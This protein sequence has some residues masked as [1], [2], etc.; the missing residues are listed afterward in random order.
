MG[1][2]RVFVGTKMIVDG[3]KRL[4]CPIWVTMY[5]MRTTPKLRRN[6]KIAGLTLSL[7]LAALWIGSEWFQVECL[8]GPDVTIY[9]VTKG[10]FCIFHT[11][12]DLGPPYYN[13]TGLSFDKRDDMFIIP[14]FIWK[15]HFNSSPTTSV[16]MIPLWSPLFIVVACTGLIWWRDRVMT[17]WEISGCCKKCGYDRRGLDATTKCPECGELGTA[18]G[19]KA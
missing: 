9:R 6:M 12:M 19:T 3:Q 4:A 11:T 17:R 10:V 8:R 18:Q 16:L 2:K 5:P 1:T 7:L 15:F 14:S 13:P